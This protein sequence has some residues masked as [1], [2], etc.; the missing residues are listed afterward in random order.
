MRLKLQEVEL[1]KPPLPSFSY[2]IIAVLTSTWPSIESLYL[3]DAR[4]LWRDPLSSD[5]QTH[6]G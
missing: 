2:Q 1:D 4:A 3:C 6:F 5:T